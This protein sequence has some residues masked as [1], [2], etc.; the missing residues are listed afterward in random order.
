MNYSRRAV[1]AGLIS[2][3]MT[4]AAILSAPTAARADTADELAAASARLQSLGAELS[5]M[6]ESLAEATSQLEKTDFEIEEK[7]DQIK[8]QRV[9]LSDKQAK[10]GE[11][12]KSSYK[13]GKTSLLD[14]VLSSANF[15]DLVTR[16]HYLDSIS[17]SHAAAISEV[18]ALATQL[19]KDK[20]ELEDKQADQRE[21]V[22]S[23]ESQ[24]SEYS[25]RVSEAREVYNS[26]DAQLQAELEAQRNAELQ[27]ALEAANRPERTESSANEGSDDHREPD[28]G[29]GSDEGSSSNGNNGNDDEGSDNG[30]SNDDGGS[31]SGNNG[32]GSGGSGGNNGGSGGS[33]GSGGHVPSG[34]GV[35]TAL[36]LIGH[37]YVYG[38]AGP[39]T[40]DCSGLVCYCYG[41]ARG[42]TTYLMI[43]SLKATGDWKTSMD[44][45]NYGDLIFPHSGHV[46][47]YLG[48]GRMVHASTPA[49]GV[50]EGPVYS[51]YGGGPY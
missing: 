51:F 33:G 15:E 26:L 32:G 21:Q 48:G 11:L 49:T 43:D 41:Y 28:T 29:S 25:S 44:Q 18:S 45:L 22:D 36:A 9:L 12:M 13:T 42:R 40:F 3:P 35:A 24:V 14:F 8:K 6:Q 17:E 46:G 47:I 39:D 38:T 34:G 2:L 5:S 4:A 16:V 31:S 37:D 23:L 1:L 10:L 50:I 7:G 20:A 27:A 19:E 30:G